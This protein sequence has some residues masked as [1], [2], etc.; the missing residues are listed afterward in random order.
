M[1][2]L[3]IQ[4]DQNSDIYIVDTTADR[5]GLALARL[6]GSTRQFIFVETGNHTR[7]QAIAFATQSQRENKQK[8]LLVIDDDC[9]ISQ[10]FITS[11]K[12]VKGYAIISP[13]VINT[14]YPQLPTDFKWFNSELEVQDAPGFS[15]KCYFVADKGI[16]VGKLVNETVIIMSSKP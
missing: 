15:T 10:T 3:Q 14:P 16:K 11:V 4:L 7:D 6:Y 5:S 2:L 8:G 12:R 1:T 13:V 9:L